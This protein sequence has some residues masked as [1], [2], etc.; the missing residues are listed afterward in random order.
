MYNDSIETK[1][2]FEHNWEDIIDNIPTKVF[3]VDKNFFNLHRNVILPALN[4]SSYYLFD[5]KESN[6]N[7]TTLTDIL[8]FFQKEKI[9]RAFHV[10]CIGGG[11]TTD[12]GSFTAS[13][14]MRG[15]KL[16]LIP[17][18][19][20]GMIDAAIG[21][22]TAINFQG[23]KNNIGSFYYADQVIINS[24]FLELLPR[25]E[26]INGWAE[27]VKVALIDG[28]NLLKKLT[29]KKQKLDNSIILEAVRIKSE[30]CKH[31]PFDN[32]KR[33]LLNLGH[34]VGHIIEVISN[35]S[36][37]HGKSVAV[38]LRVI[39]GISYTEG[40]ISKSRYIE[41]LRLLSLYEL[42]FKQQFVISYSSIYDILKQDKKNRKL[43]NLVLFNETGVFTNE[44]ILDQAALLIEQNINNY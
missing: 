3:V 13:I 8:S 24:E 23:I 22:K 27:C 42:D 34:S 6:K 2:I 32:E 43:M 19:F 37:S 38:G 30:I 25:Q 7:I 21:G 36:I 44:I 31:D 26:L 16:V 40:F 28:G 33:Q 41:I 39:A 10:V 35:F 1:V 18:T 11:I 12:I 20:L 14:Y 29:E 9:N 5:A 15:C 17:T 4:N